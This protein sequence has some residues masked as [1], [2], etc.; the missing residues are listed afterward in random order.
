VILQPF[1]QDIPEVLA[2]VDIFVLPS[3]WEAF[4]IALLEAM[5]MGKAVIGTAIDG[6]PE[7]ISHRDNGLLVNAGRLR[8]E[9]A[10]ALGELGENAALRERLREQAIKSIYNRYNVETLARRNEE[11]YRR[12]V[13]DQGA[14]SN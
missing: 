14:I 4:P 10:A 5:S 6:T 12:L 11:I 8:E 3:L 1:R 2:A 13:T 9:L 7:I